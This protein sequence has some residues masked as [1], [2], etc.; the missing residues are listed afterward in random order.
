M[1]DGKHFT[2]KQFKKNAYKAKGL[3]TAETHMNVF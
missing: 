3:Y 1:N 2:W